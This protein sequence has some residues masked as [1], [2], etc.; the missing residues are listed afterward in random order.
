MARGPRILAPEADKLDQHSMTSGVMYESISHIIVLL[1]KTPPS[2][3][4]HN[5]VTAYHVI[6]VK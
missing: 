4:K 1:A 3:N 2:S 6:Y 5:I